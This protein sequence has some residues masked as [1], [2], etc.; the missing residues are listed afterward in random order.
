[1]MLRE[2]VFTT[3]TQLPVHRKLSSRQGIMQSIAL[4]FVVPLF[5][6]GC[7]PAC[8]VKV[9]ELV[10]AVMTSLCQC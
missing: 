8:T 2:I 5:L 3:Y 10:L 4:P 6:P 7:M 9:T 1:M